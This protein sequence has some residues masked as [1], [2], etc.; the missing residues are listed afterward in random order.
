MTNTNKLSQE[1]SPYLLQHAHN[2]V[3]WYPWGTEAFEKAAQEDKPIF[4]SIG[5]STC[6]WCHVMERESFEDQDVADILNNYYISIKVDREERPDIDHIY[7]SV[8]QALTMSGGWPLTI[9][10]TPD[11]KPF[12]AGTY[13][14]KYAKMGLLGLIDILTAIAKAWSE[15]KNLLYQ[16]GEDIINTIKSANQDNRASML[17]ENDISNAFKELSRT[18]DSTYGGFGCA[19]KFPMPHS[20]MFLLRYWKKYKEQHALDIV[21]KTLTSMYNGGIFD[22]IGFGFSRYSTDRQWLVPHFEKMLYDN[23]LLAIAYLEAFQATGKAIYRNVAEKIFDYVLRTM[24]SP[25]GGFY[26]AEDADSEGEE[27]KFYTW[28]KSEIESLLEPSDAELFCSH[29]DITSGGN[30]EEKN[31]P[32]LI[33]SKKDI[34]IEEEKRLNASREKLFDYREKKVH[35]YKDDKILTSWNGLMI[36]ALSL[37]YRVLGNKSYL[38]SAE[39]AAYF[40]INNLTD[41]NGRLLARYR[42][43]ESAYPGYIDDYSFFIWGLIELYEASH[44]PEHLKYAIDFNQQLIDAFWDKEDGGLYMYGSDSEQLLLRPKDSYDG[45]TPSGNSVSTMNF[46]RLAKLTGKFELEDFA[47]KQFETF[48][49]MVKSSP[50]SHT[51]FLMSYLFSLTNAKEVV[52]VGELHQD[53]TKKMIEKINSLFLPDIV[54]HVTPGNGESQDLAEIAPFLAGHKL[55]NDSATAYICKNFSCQEPITD[56]QYFEE[57]I[58]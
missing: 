58:K 27:G 53:Q 25:E 26:S 54:F 45:S 51:F 56:L 36:S 21:E 17:S 22:H 35:P 24:T 14:P 46:L 20:L 16:S 8:C 57:A 40:I 12:F 30:F 3:N 39:K 33:R 5:Y 32:N 50:A 43:G 52:I 1:K 19:P 49:T 47:K 41:K 38:N 55:I 7:M 34:S 11:K 44:K 10:M 9:I 42:D 15:N 23:S 28:T 6:H 2:P 4:L 37:G 31:I 48:G 13:F 18:F 29:Y